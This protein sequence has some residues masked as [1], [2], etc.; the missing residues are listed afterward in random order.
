[1][2]HSLSWSGCVF[3]LMP[4]WWMQLG[5]MM[6]EMTVPLLGQLGLCQILT[7][8]SIPHFVGVT[9]LTSVELLLIFT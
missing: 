3:S 1:M 5:S 2:Y 7:L 9:P 8:L 6:C 4:Y